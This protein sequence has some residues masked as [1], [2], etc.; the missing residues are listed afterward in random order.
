MDFAIEY[1]KCSCEFLQHSLFPLI[2]MLYVC[3]FFF[4]LN[5]I[6]IFDVWFYWFCEYCLFNLSQVVLRIRFVNYQKLITPWSKRK[7]KK[8]KI[9]TFNSIFLV[10]SISL[11]LHTFFIFQYILYII[12]YSTFTCNK[13]TI[14]FTKKQ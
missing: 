5:L 2:F 7:C 12:F 13:Y 11:K 10:I 3:L 9:G 8:H 6:Y 1:N 4:F 14:I